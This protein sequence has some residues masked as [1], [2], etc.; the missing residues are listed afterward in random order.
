MKY[1]LLFACRAFQNARTLAAE[2]GRRDNGGS[3]GGAVAALVP[4]LQRC[5]DAAAGAP[6]EGTWTGEGSGGWMVGGA[7][8]EA[9]A[10]PLCRA[11][12][13]LS[14]NE[15]VCRVRMPA[16]LF[17]AVS[18]HF[19]APLCFWM[20][21]GMVPDIGAFCCGLLNSFAHCNFVLPLQLEHLIVALI[22]SAT[23]QFLWCVLTLFATYLVVQTSLH[24]CI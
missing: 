23:A 24:G 22:F 8:A 3:N 18:R 14:V 20:A 19:L 2:G 13:A 7:E 6:G 9:A 16:L 5:A 11:I 10:P 17:C 15:D 21:I 12:K 4:L 1:V